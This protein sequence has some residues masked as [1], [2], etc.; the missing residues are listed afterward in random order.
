MKK[1]FLFSLLL[2]LGLF[3]SV[4]LVYANIWNITASAIG[5]ISGGYFGGQISNMEA[6]E[7]VSLEASGYDCQ[8]RGTT[9]EILSTNGGPTSYFIPQN[10][11]P[12]TPYTPMT[13]QQILGSY[14][15]TTTPEDIN[16]TRDE[17]E[18]GNS[19]FLGIGGTEDEL[20]TFQTS[21]KLYIIRYFGTSQY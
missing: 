15:E 1:I 5:D 2:V 3:I 16:C 11:Q 13:G 18:E 12:V 19:G 9:I 14:S 7:I 20:Q 10:V 8:I 4:K 6:P 17:I 21:P